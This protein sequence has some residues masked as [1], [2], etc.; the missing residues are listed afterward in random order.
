MRNGFTLVECMLAGSLLCIAAV[1]LVQ[2]LGVLSRVAAENAETLEAD[3]LTWDAIAAEFNREYD[4][5][6][7][8][9]TTRVL[10]EEEAPRLWSDAEGYEAKL[11]VRVRAMAPAERG[12]LKSIE[13]W[14][15][16]GDRDNRKALTNCVYRSNIQRGEAE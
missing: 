2:G 13:S 6:A 4:E 16:W 10:T 8:G 15:E 3:A 9:R 7:L 11:T 1:G 12:V 14:V 5:I